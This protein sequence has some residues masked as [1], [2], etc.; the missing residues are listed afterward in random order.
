MKI[1]TYNNRWLDEMAKMKKNLT[2][3]FLKVEY[4]AYLKDK[5]RDGG[6]VVRGGV[7]DVIINSYFDKFVDKVCYKVF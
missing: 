5:I 3:I 7:V 4:Y 2:L 1:I 6:G